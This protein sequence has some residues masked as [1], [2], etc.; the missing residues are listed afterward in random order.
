MMNRIFVVNLERC[1]DK[2]KRM[3]DRLGN[4]NYTMTKGVDGEN[5]TR[6]KLVN[7]GAD[8]LKDWKDPYSGRNIT[9]G[10]VGC[11]MSHCNIYEEYQDVVHQKLNNIARHDALMKQQQEDSRRMKALKKEFPDLSDSDGSTVDDWIDTLAEAGRG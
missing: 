3:R 6:E 11:T 5:L 1:K 10:E 8:I 4:I 9:W 2:N 7:M